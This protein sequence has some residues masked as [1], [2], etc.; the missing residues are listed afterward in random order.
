LAPPS[1]A[2]RCCCSIITIDIIIAVVAVAVVAHYQDE[3]LPG[4]DGNESTIVCDI[5]RTE[6]AMHIMRSGTVS[7]ESKCTWF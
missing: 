5:I 3:I 4:R 7:N 6:K 1:V 2:F